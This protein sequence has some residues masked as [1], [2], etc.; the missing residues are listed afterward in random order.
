MVTTASIVD[1]LPLIRGSLH[2]PLDILHRLFRDF[3]YLQGKGLVPLPSHIRAIYPLYFFEEP[4]LSASFHD[5]RA[6]QLTGRTKPLT[7]RIIAYFPS[8]NGLYYL[9]ESIEEVE[10]VYARTVTIYGWDYSPF[11]PIGPMTGHIQRDKECL[12]AFGH[13]MKITSEEWAPGNRSMLIQKCFRFLEAHDLDFIAPFS[14]PVSA[15]DRVK[16]AIES[17]PPGT[18]FPFTP[19]KPLTEVMLYVGT[20]GRTV[21]MVGNYRYLYPLSLRN[22]VE[23]V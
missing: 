17:L 21:T 11:P 6:S 7:T 10:K 13:T 5:V 1:E 8:Q 3:P 15:R 16:E 23:S 19:G 2:F 20:G 14:A 22:A 18:D 4:M 9:G 12:A